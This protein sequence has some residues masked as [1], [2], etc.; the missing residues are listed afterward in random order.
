[1]EGYFSWFLNDTDTCPDQCPTSFRMYGKVWQERG[2]NRLYS[3]LSVE[4]MWERNEKKCNLSLGGKS[5]S[6]YK[7]SLHN[8][9]LTLISESIEFGGKCADS[10]V[11]VL[12]IFSMCLS[13]LLVSGRLGMPK[14]SGGVGLWPC[15]LTLLCSTA[16]CSA[17]CRSTWLTPAVIWHQTQPAPS[18]R[19]GVCVCVCV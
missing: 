4:Y 15:H 19:W 9:S 13:V 16:P 6:S 8:E 7:W 2:R 14:L 18:R 12:N 3:K 11:R 1:M 10:G 5:L 17:L